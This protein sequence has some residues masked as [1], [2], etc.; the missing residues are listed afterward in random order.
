MGGKYKVAL[1]KRRVKK[2]LQQSGESPREASWLPIKFQERI[3][4]VEFI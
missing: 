3:F 2:R 4:P 1:V